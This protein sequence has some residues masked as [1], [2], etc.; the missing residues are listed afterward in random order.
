MLD[1]KGQETDIFQDVLW[2]FSKI[3]VYKNLIE[4]SFYDVKYC[5]FQLLVT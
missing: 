3:N 1:D 5:I 2:D 4:R